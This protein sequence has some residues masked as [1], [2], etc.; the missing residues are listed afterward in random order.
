MASKPEVQTRLLVHLMEYDPGRD[1]IRERHLLSDST[2]FRLTLFRVIE[3]SLQLNATDAR[4]EA[5]R[6][7]KKPMTADGMRKEGG[8]EYLLLVQLSEAIVVEAQN[9]ARRGA[10]RSRAPRSQRLNDASDR[11]PSLPGPNEPIANDR[12]IA[13]SAQELQ[14]AFWWRQST[15][16]YI[17]RLADLHHVTVYV[18]GDGT[19][20]IGPPLNRELFATL[21]RNKALQISD[22]A[23]EQIDSIVT[24]IEANCPEQYLGSIVRELY[25]SRTREVSVN[26]ETRLYYDIQGQTAAAR[27]RGGFVARAVV[28][29]AFTLRHHGRTAEIISTH[30]DDDIFA[31]QENRRQYFPH[32]RSISLTDYLDQQPADEPLP[33]AVPLLRMSGRHGDRSAQGLIVGE[34]DFLADEH[35]GSPGHAPGHVS[36][37]RLL[38]RALTKG[39]VIFV[40]TSLGDP[41]VLAA[42]ATTR[43]LH[44]ERYAL[45][46]APSGLGPGALPAHEAAVALR[47]LAM[48][49]LHL[50]VTPVIADLDHQIPQLLREVALK[51]DKGVGYVGYDQR[52]DHWWRQWAPLLG[53]DA[54]GSR[55]GQPDD[56]LLGLWQRRLQGLAATIAGP[57]VLGQARGARETIRIEVWLRNHHKRCLFLWAAAPGT[58]PD[59]ERVEIDLLAEGEQ[60]VAQL[61]FRTGR[62]VHRKLEGES[63]KYCVSTNMVLFE[64][65]WH[66]LPVGIVNVLSERDDGALAELANDGDALREFESELLQRVK[67]LL[68]D[69]DEEDELRADRSP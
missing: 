15:K 33:D 62:T 59:D 20:D 18:G 19:S 10:A 12:Y 38:E 58:V 49:Y 11:R 40:G 14:E 63:W 5:S 2:R 44:T 45:L 65:P 7:I 30:Y 53:Y 1:P 4:E 64:T 26:A 57:S 42:L 61:A 27:S 16:T 55:S 35:V 25:R 23:P 32:L 9:Q 34:A 67:E 47:L 21:I 69:Y 41:G 46:L 51:V 56:E 24:A 13:L 52:M 29:L 22:V 60:D 50:G 28:L 37:Y 66:R 54:A 36:R 39:G 3:E 48:R 31:A 43:H 68:H 6:V 8:P 17:A